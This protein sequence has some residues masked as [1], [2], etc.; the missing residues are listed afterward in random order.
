MDRFILTKSV[1]I[2]GHDFWGRTTAV[3]IEPTSSRG[4][5]WQVNGTDVHINP[6]MLASRRNRIAL[7]H[8]K[9]ELHVFEHLGALRFAGLDNVRLIT[10]NAWLPYDG[11]AG[12]FWSACQPY[13]RRDGLSR[14]YTAS[15]RVSVA[16]YQGH[17]ERSVT[18][19]PG[20]SR[21][22]EVRVY[23]NYPELGELDRTWTFPRVSFGEIGYTKTQ[24]WPRWRRPFAKVASRLGWPHER[25]VIWPQEH[26]AEHTLELFARHRALDIV[27]ALS[28]LCPA[29]GVLV[30]KVSSHCAGHADDINLINKCWVT[31]V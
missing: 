2:R 26:S 29:G 25:A 27:G 17:G 23:I 7:M 3:R 11:S 5:Y 12:L 9:R 15:Q 22:L 13:I 8:D 24:G 10:D 30:G 31:R 6:S 1:V 21:T 4:W 19:E 14:L 16:R 28:V 18:Y 20:P